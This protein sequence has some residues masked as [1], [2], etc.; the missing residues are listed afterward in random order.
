MIIAGYQKLSLLDYPKTPCAILFTQGCSFRCAFCHNPELIPIEGGIRLDHEDVFANLEKNKKMADAVTITG[1]EPTL[2]KDL[3]EFMAKLKER[4]FRVKLD[5]N[6][7]TPEMVRRIIDGKLADYF[8]MDL[9][10]TWKKYDEIVRVGAPGL[11][12]RVKETFGLIQDSGIDH[13][14]RT[15][16]LPHSHKAEDFMEMTGYLKEG[17]KYFIQD[18]RFNITL[19]PDLPRQKSF[20]LP[21]LLSQLR[22]AYPKISIAAR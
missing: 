6:G 19:E 16:I 1:G 13:E 18:I 9:K 8:A 3:P 11:I 14:F 20:E 5:T 15:T 2:Q 22:A 21:A 17:E 4:G 10:Q 7:V 12:E